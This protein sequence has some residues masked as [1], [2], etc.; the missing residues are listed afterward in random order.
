MPSCE[1]ISDLMVVYAS[2]EA[3]PETQRLVEEHLARCPDCRQAFGKE[4][5]AEGALAA[6]EPVEEPANG[7]HFI[8]RTRRLL[9]AIGAGALSLFACVLAGFE[10]VVMEEIAAIPLP[11]LPGPAILWLAVTATMLGLYATLSLWRRGRETGRK[12][13][14][15]SSLL[16]TVP[17]LVITL[18]VYNLVG[19]GTV[20]SVLMAVLFLLI[21]LGITAVLLPRLPYMTL[22]TV[23]VLLLV[24]GLLLGRAVAG[25]VAVG[26]FSWQTPAGLG[27]PLK[28][29]L[30]ETI[31]LS[32]LGLE[33]V[34]STKVT[35]VDNV[36]IGPRAEAVR[37]AY[38]GTDR[39]GFLTIVRFEDQQAADEFFSSWSDSVSGGVRLTH[40]EIN[41]PGLSDQGRILRS[42]NALAGKAYNAWQTEN[43][44]TIV[45]VPGAFSQATP[46][47][48][49]IKDVVASG[50]QR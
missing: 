36:W 43:W 49:E 44:V 19:T 15:L 23:L 4:H 38:E 40:F 27:H 1:V 10:R 46:L 9:F 20:P 13:D 32:P 41:L 28:V 12:N 25:I 29:S 8:A 31:D 6:L 33:W 18:A 2:G 21:T 17:L 35:G 37:A 50:Y 47:S 16:M 7:R 39:Q 22:A 26:D 48:R 34:E 11:R 45:E 42:Y 5:P 30:E 3:S 14:I 24:N